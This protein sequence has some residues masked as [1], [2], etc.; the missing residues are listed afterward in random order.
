[1]SSSPIIKS[2]SSAAVALGPA[3]E[4]RRQSVLI[5]D[6]H[7][8]TRLMLKTILEMNR[9]SVLEAADGLSLLLLPQRG[10]VLKPNVAASATLGRRQLDRPTATRLCCFMVL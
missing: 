5:A 9:F 10:Y 2:V 3:I 6:D 8:D 7:E 1:M 4:G